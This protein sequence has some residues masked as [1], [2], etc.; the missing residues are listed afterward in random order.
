MG[1]LYKAPSESEILYRPHTSRNC[2]SPD[3]VSSLD[4]TTVRNYDKHN[5][6]ENSEL[7]RLAHGKF[8]TFETTDRNI[9]HQQ[10]IADFDLA[11]VILEATSNAI[12]DLTPLM[13]RVNDALDDPKPGTVSRISDR[14]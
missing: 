8:Y 9:P 11:I 13:E 10:N 12:E 7:L 2:D 3:V 14:Q 5:V 6:N 1:N 4:C